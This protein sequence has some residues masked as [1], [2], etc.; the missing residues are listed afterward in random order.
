MVKYKSVEDA[1]KDVPHH[2]PHKV[3]TIRG[4]ERWTRRILNNNER[5]ELAMTLF[6]DGD[7]KDKTE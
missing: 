3:K 4:A 7:V 2:V 5:W 1:M 6:E